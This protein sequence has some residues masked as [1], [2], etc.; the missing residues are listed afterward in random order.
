MLVC[1]TGC[2]KS[3]SASALFEIWS[4]EW[5]IEVCINNRCKIVIVYLTDNDNSVI[6]IVMCLWC[7]PQLK[8]YKIIS[9][10]RDIFLTVK[11]FSDNPNFCREKVRS[12]GSLSQENKELNL[13]RLVHSGHK[14]EQ[15]AKQFIYIYMCVCVCF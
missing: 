2:L 5:F 4:R 13:G 8:F 7:R 12:D 6:T 14:W 15:K 11:F 9:W 1:Q 10:Q 3:W